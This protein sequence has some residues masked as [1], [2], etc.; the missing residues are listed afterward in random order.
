MQ[1]AA[2][3][4]C[5]FRL[6][7]SRQDVA[8]LLRRENLLTEALDVAA[9]PPGQHVRRHGGPE[10]AI[11]DEKDDRTENV[12][13]HVQK[14]GKCLH[15]PEILPERVLEPGFLAEDALGPLGRPFVAEYPPLHVLR[16]DDEDPVNRNENVVDLGGAALGG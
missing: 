13:R 3:N 10:L 12:I 16:L 6:S 11:T 15:M 8:R 14:L 5:G 9:E 4:W 1:S 7:Q 2:G